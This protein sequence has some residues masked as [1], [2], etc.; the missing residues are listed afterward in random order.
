MRNPFVMFPAVVNHEYQAQMLKGYETFV[1][2]NSNSGQQRALRR[3]RF[4]DL[5]YCFRKGLLKSRMKDGLRH[6]RAALQNLY[7]SK[8]SY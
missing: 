8:Y 6:Y 3:T 4:P 7:Y 5:V 2:H 1:W